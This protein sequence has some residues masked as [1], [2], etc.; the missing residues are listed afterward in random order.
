ML[1]DL[2]LP[3]YVEEFERPFLQATTEFYMVCDP[4]DPVCHPSRGPRRFKRHHFDAC[5]WKH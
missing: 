3:V 5:E 2:G 1:V 4:S